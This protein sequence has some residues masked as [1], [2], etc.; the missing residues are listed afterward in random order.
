MGISKKKRQFIKRNYPKETVNELALKT[1]LRVT[2]V[3][4]ILGI[5]EK[6]GTVDMVWWL[7]RI[8]EWG[9]VISIFCAPFV[10]L[11]Q[12]RDG[13]NLPQNAFIQISTLVLA[14]IWCGKAICE[15][16]IRLVLTPILWPLFGFLFWTGTAIFWAVNP[17]E[18]IP[19]FLQTLAMVI[20]F[21]LVVH[22][23][24]NKFNVD[25]IIAAVVLSGAVIAMIG[26]FQYLFE[27]TLIPQTRPP[28]A[29]FAN[30][31]MA[32]QFMVLVLPFFWYVFFKTDKKAVTWFSGIGLGLVLI[33]IVYIKSLAGWIC[34]FVQII[35][36][37]GGLV[38]QLKKNKLNSDIRQKLLP[39]AFVLLMFF[40]MIH[41][42]PQGVNSRFGRVFDQTSDLVEF[43][44]SPVPE[45]L[46]M[47]N[48]GDVSTIQWRWSIWMNSLALLR[49]NL[50]TGVGP[51][52]FR[53]LYP[54]YSNAV[55][56]D[57][58]FS[59]D[60]QPVYV[61]N[62]YIQVG[63]EYGV[64]GL[65][66]FVSIILCFGYMA[67]VVFRSGVSKKKGSGPLLLLVT[68]LLASG[69]GVWLNAVFSFPFHRAVPPHLFM[70][71]AGLLSAIFIRY[72]GAGQVAFYNM[73]LLCGMCAGLVIVTGYVICFYHGAILFDQHYGRVITSYNQNRWHN[74]IDESQKARKYKPV[75]NDFLDFYVGYAWD[76]M[77]DVQKSIQAYETLLNAFPNYLNGLI[78]LGIAYSKTD[79]HE[80]AIEMYKK[81]I[82][83][84]P[85]K[86]Q[87]YN[88][89]GHHYLEMGRPEN[90]LHYFETAARLGPQNAMVHSNFGMAC[91]E[92][93]QFVKAK[94]SFEK[95]LEIRPE[96][97][98]PEYFLKLIEK[99]STLEEKQ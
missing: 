70:L 26:I 80:K 60:T 90:A 92:L 98:I 97:D 21:I 69:L 61:H 40:V 83:I 56:K 67:G 4:T 27:W 8:L 20:F 78:K 93:K 94:Q 31:N 43:A 25:K 32:S 82:R 64:P 95:A 15:K 22:G 1:G 47:D 39:G 91:L 76:N 17:N 59:I 68:A 65:I 5:E 13:A 28:A 72:R 9:I 23:Y 62:D 74:L 87:Y 41:L 75:S 3:Q 57:Y 55:I 33:Y 52:N 58:K 11:P 48:A 36:L 35:V 86:F 63:V 53:I 42:G 44:V 79:Q 34:A 96:W 38:F 12:L 84:L 29:T 16:K 10:V 73:K 14:S 99:Q 46:N 45:K 37:S 54:L 77:G 89:I 88:D 30:R 85:D 7:D 6:R 2:D 19:V 24:E 71:T 18:G 81:V 49:D 51:G 66:M 50:L